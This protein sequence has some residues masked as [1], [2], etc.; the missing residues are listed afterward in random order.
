MSAMSFS[1]RRHLPRPSRARIE[2]LFTILKTAGSARPARRAKSARRG[3]EDASV[4]G[5]LILPPLFLKRTA[6]V[7]T[8]ALSWGPDRSDGPSR[9]T[10]LNWRLVRVQNTQEA[11]YLTTADRSRWATRE[12][13]CSLSSSSCKPRHTSRTIIRRRSPVAT[14]VFRSLFR[15]IDSLRKS[16]FGFP[17]PNFAC[18]ISKI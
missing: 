18:F 17:N 12:L 15:C 1:R 9:G 13:A 4:S 3:W 8:P 7:H 11:D 14:A 5:R 10:S 6:A 16:F 2:G